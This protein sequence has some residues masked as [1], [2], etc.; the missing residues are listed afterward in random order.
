ME[1]KKNFVI[2]TAFYC[3]LAALALVFWKYLL[4]IL[5]PFVIGFVI[6]SIVQLPLKALP[7]KGK[8]RT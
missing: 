4:P 5:M 1:M 7:L 6:A 8:R 3:I 2:N